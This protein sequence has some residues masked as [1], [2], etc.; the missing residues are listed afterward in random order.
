MADQ[1]RVIITRPVIGIC[2]MQVCACA[3][4]TDE[5]M[6]RVCNAE[7]PSGTSNGWCTVYR[8]ENATRPDGRPVVCDDDPSRRHFIIAC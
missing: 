5:E 7:N 3:D 8:D 1:P 6:L 2:Y 4:A